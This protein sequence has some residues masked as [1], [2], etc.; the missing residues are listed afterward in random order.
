VVDDGSALRIEPVDPDTMYVPTYDPSEVYINTSPISYSIGYP[1][2]LWDDD[3]FD[4]GQQYVV[5]GGGWY[6]G[7]HHP[8]AWDQHPPAWDRHPAGWA[9]SPKPWARSAQAAAAPRLSSASVA[10]LNLSQPRGSAAGPGAGMVRPLPPQ[11]PVGRPAAV[12]LSNN[13][14]DSAQSRE[15][16]QRAQQRARPMQAAPEPQRAVPIPQRVA[17]MPEPQRAAPMPQ[18]IAPMPAPPERSGPGNAFSGGSGGDT[19]AQSSRGNASVGRR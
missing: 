8:A 16:T 2:G 14:F 13:A 6:R 9:A 11:V 1:I 4:W 3:D 18:R 5:V 12:P 17:P 10:H 7:W 19:R 15:D